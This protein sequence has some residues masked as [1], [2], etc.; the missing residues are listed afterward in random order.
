MRLPR[1]GV[2]DGHGSI[3]QW[4]ESSFCVFL[5]QEVPVLCQTTQNRT[6]IHLA[7]ELKE[8]DFH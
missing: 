2:E 3:H 7:D 1:S 8:I 6:S 4:L 5:R